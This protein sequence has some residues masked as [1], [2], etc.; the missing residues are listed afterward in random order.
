M[1]VD[2]AGLLQSFNMVFQR[3]R[4]SNMRPHKRKDGRFAQQPGGC[5]LLIAGD[6]P[7]TGSSIC[8]SFT[9][10]ST[11]ESH[12]VQCKS[13]ASMCIGRS[14]IGS[15]ML[16]GAIPLV[17]DCFRRRHLIRGEDG[18]AL[19]WGMAVTLISSMFLQVPR[20]IFRSAGSR[21]RK[22]MCPSTKSGMTS[23]PCLLDTE[24][25]SLKPCVTAG[26]GSEPSPKCLI[27]PIT[28]R[29]LV[30]YG[31]GWSGVWFSALATL[32]DRCHDPLLS[33]QSLDKA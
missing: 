14:S 15:S 4:S 1:N 20:R 7:P 25:P 18:S 2:S 31:N 26:S 3:S 11:A 27:E 6:L 23:R 8:S 19:A 21:S 33:E 30:Q 10:L 32:A 24:A 5:S 13:L 28:T 12:P 29:I 16:A 17:V 9:S 22:C